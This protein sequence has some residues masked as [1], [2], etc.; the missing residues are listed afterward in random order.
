MK[1]KFFK[2]LSFVLALAMIIS[3]VAPAASAF[4]ATTVKLNSSKVYLHLDVEDKNEF[5]FN[6][7]SKKGKGWKYSWESSNEKV[8]EVNEK[9]GIVTA[10]GV[11]S[12]KVTLFVTDKEGE[13]IDDVT[14]T[15]V[16]RDNI[17]TVEI[18]NKPE[19]DKLAVGVEHDFNRNFETVSGSTTKTSAITRWEVTPAEGATIN[20]K[21]VFVA[22]KAGKYTI[23][24]RS[25]QSKE[26]YNLWINEGKDYVLATDTYEVTVA[27]SV[28]GTKQINKTKFAVEFDSSMKDTDLSATTATVYQVINGKLYNTGTEKIKS[29]TLDTEGKVATVEVYG[30]FVGKT[31]YQFVYGELKGEFTAAN[32][33]L[34]EVAGIVF[35]DFQAKTDGTAVNMLEKVNAVNKDGVVILSGT[36]IAAYLTFEYGGDYA[37][38][39]VDGTSAYINKDGY[40]GKV[41]AK[42][43]NFVYDEATQTY[44][45]V[46]FQDDAMALGVKTIY[47]NTTMQYAVAKSKPNTWDASKWLTNGFSVP[48]TDEG[49]Q[50]F[51]RYKR[52]TDPSYA[53]YQYDDT[54]S[55]FKYVSTNADKLVIINNFLYPISQGVVTVLVQDP[56]NNNVT[57]GTFDITIVSSRAYASADLNVYAVSLGNHDFTGADGMDDDEET[58]RFTIMNRDTMGD[59]LLVSPGTPEAVNPPATSTPPTVTASVATSDPTSSDYGKVYLDVTAAGATKGS[60]Q[61]KVTLSA[62]NSTKTV[63]VFVNVLE[64]NAEK[65]ALT[66]VT[67]WA[68]EFDNANVDLKKLEGEKD[69]EVNVYG[70]NSNNARIYALNASQ[71]SLVVKK[72][73]TTTDIKSV[74]DISDK[75]ATTE[76]VPVAYF[77]EGDASYATGAGLAFVDLSSYV[78]TAKA[79]GSSNPTGRTANATIGAASFTIADTSEL[80]PVREN[81]S[82]SATDYPSIADAVKKAFNFKINGSDVNEDTAT[83]TYKVTKGGA[84]TTSDGSGSVSQGE[85]LY[86]HEVYYTTTWD[87]GASYIRYTFK[88]NSI[89]TITK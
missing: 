17:K 48:A 58:K 15:V 74:A 60:Y 79:V 43:N 59:A 24:A 20:D 36:D 31:V 12:A 16:V 67:R 28:V 50:I 61:F 82:V 51:T 49:F 56:A 80:V 10:T 18:A 37:Y 89:V 22:N 3:V 78:V 32:N 23:T 47:S 46:A 8:V 73:S 44:K 86:V 77:A 57:V 7:T 54:A 72:G 53:D 68:V 55:T 66:D 85:N 69:V 81:Y 83:L 25:F 14:A 70:Y 62:L 39:W 29:L 64:G 41:T 21:G 13:E 33:E 87:S 52:N 4:A 6:I 35:D 9:N 40:A 71:F 38:G 65:S 2:K 19:G 27:A 5:N 42:Y 75:D 11:G 26:K 30:N 63:N 1:T 34:S 76:L 84:L 88:V 45:T